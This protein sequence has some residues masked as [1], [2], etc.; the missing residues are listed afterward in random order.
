MQCLSAYTQGP[1]HKTKIIDPPAAKTI[2][3]QVAEISIINSFTNLVLLMLTMILRTID[4]VYK[5]LLDSSITEHAAAALLP[6]ALL[7]TGS[8]PS[9]YRRIQRMR[10]L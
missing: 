9:H 6:G 4:V 3:T 8:N 1:K 7:L 10:G 5:A 2:R